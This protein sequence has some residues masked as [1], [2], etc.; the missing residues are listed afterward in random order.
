MSPVTLE[1]PRL[2]WSEMDADS[3]PSPVGELFVEQAMEYADQL[4]AAAMRLA[5]NPADAAD[6][7][8][9]TYLKAYQAFDR[10]EQGTNLKAWLYRILTNTFINLYRKRQKTGIQEGLEDLEEWQVG[11]SESLT[12]R[13]ARSAEAEAIDHMPDSAVRDALHALPEER[14]LVIYFADVEGYSYQEIADIMDT[15]V[16]TVMSR[17]HRGRRELREALADYAPQA[18]SEVS[19][20]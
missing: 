18:E 5:K 4:Y 11:E 8:Q 7:V 12:T 17:L 6:L 14:R 1:A 9:E 10:F 20:G 15:P 13:A 2:D 3:A 16:G 19:N